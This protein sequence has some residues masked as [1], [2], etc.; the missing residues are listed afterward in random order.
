V[1]KNNLQFF[2]DTVLI[3]MLFE[4]SNATPLIQKSTEAAAPPQGEGIN[5]NEGSRPQDCRAIGPRELSDSF[6]GFEWALEFT[7][8]FAQDRSR[9][10]TRTDA[11]G[12]PPMSPR[13]LYDLIVKLIFA[14]IDAAED[15]GTALLATYD[16]LSHLADHLGL[17]EDAEA[18]RRA[19]A[20]IRH[21]DAAEAA[22]QAE[23][24]YFAAILGKNGSR[25]TPPAARPPAPAIPG[26][27][28]L[29]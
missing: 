16:A 17:P 24:L 12:R 18:A 20:A 3:H 13:K 19:A 9:N 1:S 23:Q 21:A 25:Q 4:R 29:Q 22:A 27:G 6:N 26:G 2:F 10:R 15:A 28:P 14:G 7:G 8:Q 5:G 11:F